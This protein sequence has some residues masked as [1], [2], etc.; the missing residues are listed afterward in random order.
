MSTVRASAFELLK[1]PYLLI[2][3]YCP[4]KWPY[5]FNRVKYYSI[6]RVLSVYLANVEVKIHK[7]LKILFKYKS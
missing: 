3:F 4:Q 5:V 7:D 2:S 6:R 1:H